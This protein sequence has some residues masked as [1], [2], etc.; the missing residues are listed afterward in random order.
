M[1][2]VFSSV[3][4]KYDVM[5]D[6]M[7]GGLHRLW[8]DKFVSMLDPAPGIHHLDVAGGTGAQLAASARSVGSAVQAS[9]QL[10]A[11]QRRI[12]SSCPDKPAGLP[13]PAIKHG[14]TGHEHAQWPDVL[15]DDSLRNCTVGDIAFRVL[16]RMRRDQTPAPGKVTV[17]DINREMIEQGKRRAG[18]RK[19]DGAHAHARAK[20]CLS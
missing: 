8:K 3:A 4:P 13:D 10:L 15:R 5:N 11:A 19:L 20:T 1:G 17:L 6:V 16:K 2:K 18:E 7:S 9:A 14:G 12:M